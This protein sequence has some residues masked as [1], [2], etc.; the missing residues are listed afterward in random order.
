MHK[1]KQVLIIASSN[2]RRWRRNP[3]IWLAFALGFIA[4]F[5]LS[6][7]V[8]A[9]AAE[10]DTALEIL[11]P[12]IWTFGDAT[13]VLIISLCL[14]LLFADMPRMDNDVP[15]YLVRC[16]RSVWTAGQ[17]VYLI[18][19]TFTFVLFILIS[20]C[21]LCGTQAFTAN[22][23]SDTAAILG[24]SSIGDSIAVPAFVKVLEFTFPYRCTGHIFLLMLGYSLLI[25]SLVFY[26]NLFKN[27]AGMV[28]GVICS[29]FGLFLT[30]KVISGW[31]HISEINVSRANILFGWLSPLNHATYYMHNFGYDE[32]PK[33]WVSYVFF[34]LISTVFFVLSFIKI[35]KYPFNFTGTER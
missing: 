5:L 20:T 27:K 32:L 28:A 6:N 19:S 4:C 25:S 23:W 34:T 33:L 16:S 24:Y 8:V 17:I 21:I 9:F 13:S 2:F 3:Q 18:V 12:F 26:F 11:E 1:I 30:P 22:M 10:Y 15:L 31:F 7:K 29:S 35:R 14:L